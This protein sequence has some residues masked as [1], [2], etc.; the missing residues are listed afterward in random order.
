ML[1]IVANDA[2]NSVTENDG[3][4]VAHLFNRWTYLHGEDRTKR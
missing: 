1:W 3:A 2:D 4:L